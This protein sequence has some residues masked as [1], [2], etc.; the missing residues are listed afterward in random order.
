MLQVKVLSLK[1]LDVQV[2]LENKNFNMKDQLISFETAESVKKLKIDLK[3]TWFYDKETKQLTLSTVDN[4]VGYN[5]DRYLGAP[6]QSFLQRWL[7]EVHKIEM[8][9][10]PTGNN[11]IKYLIIIPQCYLNNCVDVIQILFDTYEE[12]LEVGLQEALKFIKI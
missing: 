12:A 6:T 5:E 7:R 4:Y 2:V 3:C 8:F 11:P 10:T 9:V 1:D